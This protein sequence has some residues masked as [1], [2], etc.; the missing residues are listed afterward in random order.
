MRDEQSWFLKRQQ[1]ITEKIGEPALLRITM[2]FDAWFEVEVKT[3]TG[4]MG[5]AA[6][7]EVETAIDQAVAMLL[8][9]DGIIT[10]V[11]GGVGDEEE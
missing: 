1:K 7:R 10:E 3:F 8:A 6:G 4:R 5:V 11:K 9:M 2:A